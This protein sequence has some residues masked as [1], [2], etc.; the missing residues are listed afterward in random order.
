MEPSISI[1]IDIEEL[2]DKLKEMSE[3]EFVTVELTINTSNYY[4]DYTLGLKA[5]N[6]SE[7]EDADYGELNCISDDF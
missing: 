2:M 7:E 1:K 3:D 4:D 6:I 5:I